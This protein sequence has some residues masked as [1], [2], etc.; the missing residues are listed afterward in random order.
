MQQRSLICYVILLVLNSAM[1]WSA[2]STQQTK[3]HADPDIVLKPE[4]QRRAID[5]QKIDGG[6]FE[7]GIYV[8]ILNIEDF[9]SDSVYGLRLAYHITEDFFV[10]TTGGFSEA[11]ETSFERLSGSAPLLTDDERE[12]TYYN[13]SMGFN[14][15]PGEVFLGSE[16]A[17][18]SALYAV[19]G[20]GSTEFAGDNRFTIN[21]GVGYRIIFRDWLALHVD[22]RDHIFDIDLLGEDKT[23]HNLEFHTGVTSFF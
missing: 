10:E 14:L 9:G 6:D 15:F 1:A 12:V 20:G 21:Y 18:N 11:G 7:A 17:F 2:D 5:L 19:L 8:G 4:L 3:S 16:H 23:T 22:M 13:L